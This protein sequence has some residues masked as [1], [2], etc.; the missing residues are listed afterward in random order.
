[1]AGEIFVLDCSVAL[2]WCFLDEREAYALDVLRSLAKTRTVVPA[3]WPL[4]VANG[5]L[6]GERRKR[7][8]GRYWR[9]VGESS[10][11]YQK[12]EHVVSKTAAW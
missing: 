4:E 1:M 2:S 7:S 12:A 6:M 10:P 3:V 5:L 8:T 11:F 9:F